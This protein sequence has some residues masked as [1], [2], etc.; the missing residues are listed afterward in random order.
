M[1]FLFTDELPVINDAVVADGSFVEDGKSV[2]VGVAGEV[3]EDEGVED[4]GGVTTQET[5]TP[6]VTLKI[7]DGIRPAVA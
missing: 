1:S 7:L 4:C 3:E 5:S 2:E 6:L